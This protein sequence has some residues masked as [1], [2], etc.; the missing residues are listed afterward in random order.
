MF[1][2]HICV[3]ES[4]G[5][6]A[7]AWVRARAGEREAWLAECR[8]LKNPSDA[9]LKT[10]N[11]NSHFNT[12]KHL[13]AEHYKPSVLWFAHVTL[14][15]VSTTCLFDILYKSY[16]CISAS[17]NT[18][19]NNAESCLIW[20][21]YLWHWFRIVNNLWHHQMTFVCIFTNLL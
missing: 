4:P 14:H 19:I 15:E 13:W 18:N 5:V 7:R 10:E 12:A 3:M 6:C 17:T 16:T 8:G 9:N 21:T 2:V 11:L 20:S 1:C